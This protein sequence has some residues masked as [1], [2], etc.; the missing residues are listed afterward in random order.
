MPGSVEKIFACARLNL[1]VA[2]LAL[3]GRWLDEKAVAASYDQAAEGYDKSWLSHLR[4]V[5]DTLLSQLPRPE[6][7]AVLDLGCGTGYATRL[8]AE[9]NPTLKV[10]GVDISEGM[11]ARA[12]ERLQGREVVFVQDDMLRFLRARSAGSASLIVS[13]WSLGYSKPPSMLL[14]AARVLEAGGTLAFVVNY[15]DTMEPVFTAFRKCLARH[16][17]LVRLAAWPRFP[18]SWEDLSRPLERG[19]FELV[20]REE[21]FKGIPRPAEGAVLPWLLRT[22]VLAGFDRMLPLREGGPAAESFESLLA[23]DP[24]PLRHHYAAV[25]ARKA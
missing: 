6:P 20:W 12:R 24:T 3:T 11:L 19:G 10:T 25:V 16:P 9:A 8:L 1:R 5:T 15:A 14:E 18:A 4:S 17:G 23:E 21:G 7:G 13:A 22:G 2:A